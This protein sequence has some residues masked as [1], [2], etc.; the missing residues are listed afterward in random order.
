MNVLISGGAGYIGKYIVD[1]LVDNNKVVIIDNL[2]TGH[3][4]AVNEKAIFYEGD[5]LDKKLLRK[6]FEKENIDVVIHMAAL[7]NVEESSIKP[8]EYYDVNFTGTLR[9]LEV[10]KEYNVNKIVFSSTAAVYNGQELVEKIDEEFPTLPI[11][12]YGRSKLFAED[13]IQAGNEANGLNYVIFRY[14]NV[15]GGKKYG[16]ELSDNKTLIPRVVSSLYLDKEMEVY[17]NDYPTNDGTC[18]RDFIFVEDLAQAH[19]IAAEKL[20]ESEDVNG[21]YNLGS[22]NGFSVQ[23]VIDISSK[24]LN[25]QVQYN[26]SERRKGD[27]AYSVASSK[28]A[29]EIL[30]W[31]PKNNDLEFIIKDVYESNYEK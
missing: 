18:V 22:E 13:L 30:G 1:L 9:L 25:K 8:Y 2:S 6:I 27:S 24:V 17:G 21:I 16:Y 11:N 31:S 7:L 10:M 26:V 3:I 28:K 23:E 5:I 4:S 29:N 14:F 12:N 15:A 19:I 20:Y